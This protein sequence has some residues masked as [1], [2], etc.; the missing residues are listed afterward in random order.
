MRRDEDRFRALYDAHAR[1]LTAYALRRVPEESADD[2]VAE[3]FLVAWRRLEEVPEDALPWLYGVARRVAANRLRTHRRRASLLS[4]LA[5]DRMPAPWT[6][7]AATTPALDALRRLRGADRE[8]LALVA[9]EGLDARA[10][11][12]TLG[13]TPEAARVRL[14]RARR[15]LEQELARP[16]GAGRLNMRETPDGA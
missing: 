9:W 15:R 3:V 10:L 5:G 13:C 8:I 11:A 4:R 2:V 6:E 16:S 7:D 14:H 1:A 12:V